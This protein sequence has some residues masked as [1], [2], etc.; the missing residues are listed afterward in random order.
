MAW[1]LL[2][3]AALLQTA[4]PTAPAAPPMRPPP[5]PWQSPVYRLFFAWNG[6]GVTGEGVAVL[7]RAVDDYR[8]N[9]RVTVEIVAAADDS[10]PSAYNL[11]LSARRARAVADGLVR[12]GIPRGAIILR[13]VGE[14]RP[15]VATPDGVRDTLNRYADI[16]FPAPTP[17]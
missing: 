1:P 5:P 11:R 12:R 2:A 9:G 7:D 15:L 13:P 10:G 14:T 3:L 16:S 17:H 8:R 4:P 6:T